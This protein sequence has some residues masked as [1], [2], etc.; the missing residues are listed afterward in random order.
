MDENAIFAAVD[1]NR[2]SG[3]DY[4]EMSRAIYHSQ[5]HGPDKFEKCDVD[6]NGL[7]DE[8]VSSTSRSAYLVEILP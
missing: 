6:A 4:V 5:K 2:D 1:Q 3:I 8:G 7:L